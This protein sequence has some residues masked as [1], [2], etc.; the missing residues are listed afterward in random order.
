[1]SPDDALRGGRWVVRRGVRRWQPTVQAR[2]SFDV[3]ENAP[4]HVLNLLERLH[5]A[6]LLRPLSP[7]RVCGCGCLCL[8]SEVCP[9]CFMLPSFAPLGSAA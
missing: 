2:P 7:H 1:M 6:M 9:N 3:D 5:V 4:T 8:P